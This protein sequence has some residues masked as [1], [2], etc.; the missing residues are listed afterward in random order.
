[1]C[2]VFAKEINNDRDSPDSFYLELPTMQESGVIQGTYCQS[3]NI[4]KDSWE[5]VEVNL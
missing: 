4:L 2:D 1:V 3:L 5:K